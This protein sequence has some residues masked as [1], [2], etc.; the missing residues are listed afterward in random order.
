MVTAAALKARFDRDLSQVIPD[1]TDTVTIGGTDYACNAEPRD[2]RREVMD[3]GF[4]ADYDLVVHVR[5]SLFSTRPSPGATA[6]R[7]G[8]TYRIENVRTSED[9][10][11]L[12]LELNEES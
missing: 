3:A 2:H 10:N 12:T 4:M 9:D 1:V 5:S 11:L 6:T 8:I 7:G